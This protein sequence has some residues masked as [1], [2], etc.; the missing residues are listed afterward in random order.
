MKI[1]V[2]MSNLSF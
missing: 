2:G 1:K